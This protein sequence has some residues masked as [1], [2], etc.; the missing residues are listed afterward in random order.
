MRI[1]GIDPGTEKSGVVEWITAGNTSFMSTP[2]EKEEIRG[3]EVMGNDDIIDRIKARYTHGHEQYDVIAIEWIQSYGMAVGKS[4]FETCMWAGRFVELAQSL[5]TPVRLIPR[6]VIKMHHCNSMRAKDGNITQ[7][8][9]DKY[10]E[11][12]TKKEP[13]FFFGVA[14]HSWQACAVAAY[15]AEGGDNELELKF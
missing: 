11:K 7:S 9:R 15:V 14:S 2:A 4:T 1:L 5:Q 10:G 6:G 8:L 3:A 12:G 13:G